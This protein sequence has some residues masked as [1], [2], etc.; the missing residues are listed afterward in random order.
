[1][2]SGLQELLGRLRIDFVL[3]VGFWRLTLCRFRRSRKRRPRFLRFRSRSLKYRNKCYESI[4]RVSGETDSGQRAKTVWALIEKVAP[5]LIDSVSM[6]KNLWTSDIHANIAEHPPST[7][8]E[9]EEIIAQAFSS[10]HTVRDP[11][12]AL[13]YNWTRAQDSS[14][15][16]CR[17]CA[18]INRVIEK[19]DGSQRPTDVLPVHIYVSVLSSDC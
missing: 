17:F 4:Y 6:F 10:N 19:L 13:V 9:C 1:M 12:T 8:P 16:A 5:D 11:D 7:C 15:H 14:R 3:W 18:L 2:I